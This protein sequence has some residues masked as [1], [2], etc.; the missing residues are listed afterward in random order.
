[1]FSLTFDVKRPAKQPKALKGKI[2]D[3]QRMVAFLSLLLQE[4]ILSVLTTC[5]GMQALCSLHA[6]ISHLPPEPSTVSTVVAIKK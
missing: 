2:Y 6:S 3:P 5:T 1:M 4:V